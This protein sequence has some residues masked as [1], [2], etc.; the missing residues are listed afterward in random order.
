[1]PLRISGATSGYIEIAANAVATNNTL[2]IPNKTATVLTDTVGDIT[3][4][5]LPSGSILQVQSNAYTTLTTTTSTS[6]INL[7]SLSIT[8]TSAS[9]K[10]LVWMTYHCSGKGAF[11]IKRGTTNL[12]TPSDGYMHF[13]S[14]AQTDWN[15]ASN[16][17]VAVYSYLDSPETTNATTYTVAMRAYVAA[18]A[19]AIGVNELTSTQNVCW[20]HAMEIA[21]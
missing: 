14:F 5:L 18:A 15:N 7:G 8:P 6:Y 13:T 20:L 1:M 4:S 16:R 19:Q 12:F 21:Q 2:T 11:V 17:W 9:S 3:R 10:I